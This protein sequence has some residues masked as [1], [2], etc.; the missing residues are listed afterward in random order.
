MA[1][2]RNVVRHLNLA[3]GNSRAQLASVL[4]IGALIIG[5]A[6]G[7]LVAVAKPLVSRVA[8]PVSSPVTSAPSG[9][10][11]S[12]TS[13]QPTTSAAPQSQ[14]VAPTT[15]PTPFAS[16]PFPSTPFA[17]TPF[18]SAPTSSTSTSPRPPATSS[19]TSAAPHTDAPPPNLD[20]MSCPQLAKA[21]RPSY[22]PATGWS[23]ACVNRLPPSVRKKTGW[24]ENDTAGWT[25]FATHTISILNT[26]NPA[27]MR[28]AIAHEWAHAESAN[29]GMEENSY[30]V[31]WL[32]LAGTKPATPETF[33]ALT[34]SYEDQPSERW[35]ETRSR[36]AGY[37][38]GQPVARTYPCATLKKF[39][40]YMEQNPGK[41]Q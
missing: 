34:Q 13:E 30:L 36:C 6:V 20:A 19:S 1:R 17:S 12:A 10:Q 31:Q 14:V 23:I 39:V 26:A 32:K 15:S 4:V 29:W 37:T 24:N 28:Q 8:A 41:E 9:Q 18:P 33:W 7:G 40:T 16:T 21:V 3:P 27:Q 38:Y 11:G 22:A 2:L 35:A 25:D 5:A